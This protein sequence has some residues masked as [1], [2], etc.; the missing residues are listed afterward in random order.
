MNTREL[1][2]TGEIDGA[3]GGQGAAG[4]RLREIAR[5]LAAKPFRPHP[6]FQGGHAQTLAGYMWPRRR[7]LNTHATDEARLFEVEPGVRLLAHCRWHGERTARPTLVLVHGLEGSSASVYMLGTAHLAYRAGFNVVRLNMRNCGATEHLTP[8]LYH[9]GMS[10]DLRAV[11]RELIER[12]RLPRL[13]LAGFSMGG[14]MV[15]KLAG[16][17]GADAPPELLGVCAVSPAL[18]LSECAERIGHRSN[19]VYQQ[20]FMRG[21]RR[22]VR[23]KKKLYPNLYD[24]R[25]LR[26]VRTIREFDEHYTAVQGGFAD[27]DDYYTQSSALFYV[28]QVRVPALVIH[29]QDDPLVPFDSFKDPSLVNH[30]HVILL[31]P[32]H[33][34]HVAFVSAGASEEERFWA[35]SRLV[36]FCRLVSGGGEES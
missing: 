25:N 8:T 13:F 14:N 30:P 31:T 33:G 29:A 22:R 35:E 16:E 15:L 17:M 27:A 18:N 9:S 2:P 28:E 7:Q 32:P 36:E 12:D 3:G 19:W 21:L 23:H 20:S 10:G 6:V 5:A 4:P 11:S 34:G 26:R 1:E 24:V